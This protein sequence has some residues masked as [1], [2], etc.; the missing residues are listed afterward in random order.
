MFVGE[1][2]G[3]VWGV[4]KVRELDGKRLLLVRPIDPETEKPLGEATMA[5]D[6][7]V[8]AGPGSIVLVVDEGGSARAI[9]G[10][11]TAPV[12]TVICGI[13]DRVSVRGKDKK[14]A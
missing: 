13:I 8:G 14:Y 6:G 12:R 9:L 11:K 1:V 7:G 10:S 2:I 5:L 4:R 3:N